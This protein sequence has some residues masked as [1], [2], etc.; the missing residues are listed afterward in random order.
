MS[1]LRWLPVAAAWMVLLLAHG[2]TSLHGLSCWAQRDEDSETCG[3]LIAENMTVEE[4]CE[5]NG[6]SISWS[7]LDDI[8][9]ED[10]FKYETLYGGVP[11]CHLCERT[12]EQTTCP[13][14]RKCVVKS[15]K[16]R[17]VCKPNCTHNSTS[18]RGP[19]CAS[20]NK[21]YRSM[22]AFL[23]MKCRQQDGYDDLHVSYLGECQ[24]SC[25]DVECLN[26]KCCVEDQHGR[27]HCVS[28]SAITCPGPFREDFVCGADNVTYETLCQLRRTSCSRGNII[29]VAYEGK[30]ENLTSCNDTICVDR[31][32]CFW[33]QAANTSR[34]ILCNYTCSG[35]ADEVPLCASD[36]QTYQSW[37][38]MQEHICQTG[39]YVEIVSWGTCDPDGRNY[40]LSEPGSGEYRGYD[41]IYFTPSS[42]QVLS[43]LRSSMYRNQERDDDNA[44]TT[45]PL[46]TTTLQ[47][48][49]IPQYNDDSGNDGSSQPV[50]EAAEDSQK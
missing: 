44:T 36:N 38:A 19:V 32:Q 39:E 41:Q 8:S 27:P 10:L 46:M 29:S 37:C 47:P 2:P 17:C 3:L 5:N 48:D 21:Q 33:D 11:D 16:P 14:G 28:Y 50:T 31:K 18:H 35:W 42:K 25:D 45:Q 23:K 34:C 12:C 49:T 20:N 4:C 22:C 7:N 24:D 9:A 6:D 15:G 40:G 43:E 13:T 30:C 26:D 1:T